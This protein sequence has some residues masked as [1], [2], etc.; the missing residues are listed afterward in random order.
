MIHDGLEKRVTA[1]LIDQVFQGMV[2]VIQTDEPQLYNDTMEELQQS[3]SQAFLPEVY[4]GESG[5][6]Y[7]PR[8]YSNFDWDLQPIEEVPVPISDYFPDRSVVCI[9]NSRQDLKTVCDLA[10]KSPAWT[11][12]TFLTYNE[13]P[14]AR[15]SNVLIGRELT[16]EEEVLTYDLS[17]VD[18]IFIN[19]LDIFN[20]PL[21]VRWIIFA[22]EMDAGLFSYYYAQ[23]ANHLAVFIPDNPIRS[24][25]KFISEEELVS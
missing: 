20:I 1:R 21:T 8:G 19:P 24:T 15:P 17:H 13:V 2:A 11:Y 3:S 10:K 12:I 6:A 16:H 22:S 5:F 23:A 9:A 4:E 7:V 18:F 25:K 14:I